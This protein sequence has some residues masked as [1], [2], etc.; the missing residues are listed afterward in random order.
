MVGFLTWLAVGA[1][2]CAV[3][4]LWRR[5]MG[6]IISKNTP[7]VGYMYR[8]WWLFILVVLSVLWP[9]VLFAAAKRQVKYGKER[10]PV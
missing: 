3:C 10:G 2:I 8:L 4:C 1:L 7:G 6:S 9:V 5:E